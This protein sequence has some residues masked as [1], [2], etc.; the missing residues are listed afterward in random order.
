MRTVIFCGLN[1]LISDV[2]TTLS[3]QKCKPIVMVIQLP[4]IKSLSI[5]Q[6]GAW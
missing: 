3:R 1:K 4:A 6:C 5:G 2:F